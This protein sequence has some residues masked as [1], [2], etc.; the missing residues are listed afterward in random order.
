[1]KE[2]WFTPQIA[3]HDIQTRLRRVDEFLGDNN[4][5]FIRI[6]FNGRQMA[7]RE[8]GPATMNKIMSMIGDKVMFE[9][10]PKFEGRSFTAIIGRNRSPKKEETTNED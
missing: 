2:L 9:R 1:M 8:Y 4:K 5:I 7:H 10:E 6:K 3:D